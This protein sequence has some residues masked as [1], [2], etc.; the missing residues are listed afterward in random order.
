MVL[1]YLLFN[2][3]YFDGWWYAYI[4]TLLIVFLAFLLWNRQPIKTLG[5]GFA[6]NTWFQAILLAISVTFIS[7]V[8]IQYLADTS[9]IQISYSHW[10]NYYHDV[11]YVLNE[12]IMLGA[13][14]LQLLM[15]SGLKP[16]AAS[17]VLA[18]GFSIIHF[19]FY[20]WIF[21]D[22]GVL[23]VLTLV[24]LFLI[25]FIRNSLILFTGHIAFSWALHFG[26]IAVMFG[27]YH[28]F[29]DG[30]RVPEPVRFNT[31]VGSWEL[32]TVGFLLT[33]ISLIY[34]RKKPDPRRLLG[35]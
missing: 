18:V 5:L 31:Y 28:A 14:V 32:F 3:H 16:M 12:E 11:F 22:R 29:L 30:T 10:K 7:Y 15:R 33:S 25:G 35:E 1:V 34:W 21:D 8:F 6:G 27:S 20:L 17:L 2:Y 26:W 13:L 23:T 4:G 19:V 24:N 9:G